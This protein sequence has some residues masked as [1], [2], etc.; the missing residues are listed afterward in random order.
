MNNLPL[1]IFWVATFT[2]FK[3]APIINI[4]LIIIFSNFFMI[5]SCKYDKSWFGL[6]IYYNDDTYLSLNIDSL[7]I[8]SA[9]LSILLW[10]VLMEFSCYIAFDLFWTI[11]FWKSIK[12]YRYIGYIMLFS[13]SYLYFHSLTSWFFFILLST[14]FLN[15]LKFSGH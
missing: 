7:A 4:F 3:I 1:S 12:F 6:L 5:N 8:Y 2:H 9:I 15:E 11:F 13:L 10:R 14:Y